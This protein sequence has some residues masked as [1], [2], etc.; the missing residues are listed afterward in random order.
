M[1][2]TRTDFTLNKFDKNAIVCQS[3][4]GFNIR[5]TREDFDSE[6][7]FIYWKNWSDCN[8]KEID[9]IGREDDACLSFEAQRTTSLCGGCCSFSLHRGRARGAAAQ[10]AGTDQDLPDHEAVPPS[11]PLLSGRKDRSR[12]CSYGGNNSTAAQDAPPRPPASGGDR[13]AGRAINASPG[14]GMAHQAR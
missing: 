3:V 2:N 7:E 9:H 1:F 4:S 13:Q 5:L 10:D 14:P 8:Y 11:V 12:D 6:E